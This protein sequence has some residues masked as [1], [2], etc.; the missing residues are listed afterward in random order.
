MHQGIAFRVTLAAAGDRR[1]AEE[2]AQDAFV[3]TIRVEGALDRADAV[4][5][6]RAMLASPSSEG[7]GGQA[8]GYP[9]RGIGSLKRGMTHPR[10][11]TTRRMGEGKPCRARPATPGGRAGMGSFEEVGALEGADRDTGLLGDRHR[12]AH[13]A[14]DQDDGLARRHQEL[15]VGET[16]LDALVGRAG[17]P[18]AAHA[19]EALEQVVEAGRRV[20]LDARSANHALRAVHAQTAEVP[21]VLRSRVVEVRQVAAVVDDALRIR[22]REPDARQRRVLEGRAPARDA[23][24]LQARLSAQT[25]PP[26]IA[27]SGSLM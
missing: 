13:R 15:V 1:D 25:G 18:E 10:M 14:V 21:V 5:V 2:A 19:D 26:L 9:I 7:Q 12:A 24:E 6:V 4:D 17:T 20:V 16:D 8:G 22:V 23:P 27:V 11:A 3:K